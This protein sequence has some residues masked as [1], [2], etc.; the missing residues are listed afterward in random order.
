MLLPVLSIVENGLLSGDHQSRIKDGA[1]TGDASGLTAID[2][3]PD[4]S[5]TGTSI[6][7]RSSNSTP[8]HTYSKATMAGISVGCT[9]GVIL[10]FA[11]LFLYFRRQYRRKRRTSPSCALPQTEAAA[12]SA[13]RDAPLDELAHTNSPSQ[14]SGSDSKAQDLDSVI[15]VH[16][17]K[18][19]V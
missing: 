12:G 18:E 3:F 6:R 11:S 16:N 13:S 10:L 8:P 17:G 5:R 7:P 19:S 4:G 9:V 15:A 2:A 14:R 1:Y